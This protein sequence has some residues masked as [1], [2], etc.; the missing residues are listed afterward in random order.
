MMMIIIIM[1]LTNN[2]M[3]LSL[4]SKRKV[5]VNHRSAKLNRITA[6]A[7][8]FCWP[9]C[10]YLTLKLLSVFFFFF[11]FCFGSLSLKRRRRRRRKKKLAKASS[12]FFSLEV[13]QASKSLWYD[14]NMSVSSA[15]GEGGDQVV[16]LP[17]SLP[18]T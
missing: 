17:A 7:T 16:F 5:K 18:S 15:T 11:S 8:F 10:R 1:I 9:D 14:N 3:H 4:S 6:T 12:H 2:K 13:H